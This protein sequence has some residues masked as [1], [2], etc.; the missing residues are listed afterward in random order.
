MSSLNSTVKFEIVELSS[1]SGEGAT[2]YTVKLDNDPASLFDKFILENG[3]AFKEDVKDII[4][5]LI[6]IGKKVGAKENFF[7]HNEGKPG[8]QV[9]ALYDTPDKHLRLYCIRLGRT[10][11][12]LGSGGP[13]NVPTWQDDAMLNKAASSMIYL[14]TAIQQKIVDGDIRWSKNKMELLGDLTFNQEDE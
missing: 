5:R 8:D 2:I 11:V 3:V 9:C 7:K 10:I 6:T 4:G 1:L 13:K 14:S 12:I